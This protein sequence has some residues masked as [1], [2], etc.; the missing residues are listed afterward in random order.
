LDEKHNVTPLHHAARFAHRD[1]V[2]WLLENGANVNA[3]GYN[4]FTPLHLTEQR[5][6]AQILIKAGARLDQKDGWGKTAL[7]YAI[8][9]RKQEIVDVILESGSKLNL[10]TTLLL[11]GRDAAVK[12]LINDPDVIVG[13]EGGK[14]LFGNTTPLGWAASE[15]DVE[16]ANLLL[17]AGASINDVTECPNMGGPATPLCNAVWKGKADMVEFL[18]K[19]GAATN[20]VGGKFYFSITEYA[21]KHS[22]PKI[23]ELLKQYKKNPRLKAEEFLPDEMRPKIKNRLP[24]RIKAGDFK[25]PNRRPDK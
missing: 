6:I 24:A 4:G 13:G 7:Q 16:L 10:Y 2:V 25:L 15:G 21:E 14:D 18:M 22:E 5:E 3:E 23:V 12:R 11:N 19:H 20:V 9:T 17:A 8:Q 1:V